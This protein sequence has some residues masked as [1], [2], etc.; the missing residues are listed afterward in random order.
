MYGG[1]LLYLNIFAVNWFSGLWNL[2]T[3]FDGRGQKSRRLYP[4][5]GELSTS[6]DF[7]I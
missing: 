1:I 7:L 3:T 5:Y 6:P 2:F 4:Y